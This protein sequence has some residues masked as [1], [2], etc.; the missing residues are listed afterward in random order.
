[1][2]CTNVQMTTAAD[3]QIMVQFSKKLQVLKTQT[4]IGR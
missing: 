3:F 1:M 2:K 4:Q